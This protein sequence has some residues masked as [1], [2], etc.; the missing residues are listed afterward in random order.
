MTSELQHVLADPVEV[1]RWLHC[2]QCEYGDIPSLKALHG[3]D[4]QRQATATVEMHTRVFNAI[5]QNPEFSHIRSEVLFR[6]YQA[7]GGSYKNIGFHRLAQAYLEQNP[8][9]NISY[10]PGWPWND[11]MNSKRQQARVYIKNAAAHVAGNRIGLNANDQQ[12]GREDFGKWT[13]FVDVI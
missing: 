10:E 3:E 4:Y 12:Y 11:S 9:L 5:F 2:K 1:G 6:L 7:N 8:H 13:F